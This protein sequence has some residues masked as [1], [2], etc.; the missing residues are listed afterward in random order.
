MKA[1]INEDELRL[2]AYLH[3]RAEG[4]DENF[5][6]DPAIVGKELVLDAPQLAKAASYLASHGLVGME[7]ADTS[8]FSGRSFLFNGL[9]LTGTGEDY[10]RELEDQPGV[11]KKIT[12]AVVREMG[13]TLRTI[14]VG[15]LTELVKRQV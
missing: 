12:V 9:W 14:A 1:N 4:Y 6:L 2:L 5:Q 8:T 13:S 11:G 10:M 3:E 15:V 7:T